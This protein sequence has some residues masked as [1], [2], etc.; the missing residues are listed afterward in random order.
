MEPRG[1]C[2]ATFWEEWETNFVGW[3]SVL[4]S[5]KQHPLMIYRVSCAGHFMCLISH[6]IIMYLD[7][8][9]VFTDP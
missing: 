4:M 2:L 9:R 7:F 3:A 5:S 1:F 8:P 6:I